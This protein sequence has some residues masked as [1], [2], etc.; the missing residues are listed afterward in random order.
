LERPEIIEILIQSLH[1]PLEDERRVAYEFLREVVSRHGEPLTHR[2]RAAF[3]LSLYHVRRIGLPAIRLLKDCIRAAFRL[4]DKTRPATALARNFLYKIYRSFRL[5]ALLSWIVVANGYF[6]LHDTLVLSATTIIARITAAQT[7]V[8]D[9]AA[10]LFSVVIAVRLRIIT[11]VTTGLTA[12]TTS[13]KSAYSRT[14]GALIAAREATRTALRNAR[15]YIIDH[16]ISSKDRVRDTARLCKRRVTDGI[17]LILTTITGTYI[18]TRTSIIRK[19]SITRTAV[20][21]KY[22][23][24]RA[25]VTRRYT[26]ARTAILHVIARIVDR[27]IISYR[28][29]RRIYADI[30]RHATR[31]VLPQPATPFIAAGLVCLVLFVFGTNSYFVISDVNRKG[32]FMDLGRYEWG[33]EALASILIGEGYDIYLNEKITEKRIK[34]L[35]ASG[36]YYE[37]IIR[38]TGYYSPLPDQEKYATGSY[39]GDIILNGRG[40]MGSDTTPVYIGMAAGP[41][42]MEFGT[43]LIIEDLAKF[44]LPMIY[45]VHDRGGAIQGNRIDIWVGKGEKAMRKAYEITGYY[46]VVVVGD[47]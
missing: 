40:I 37:R 8:I 13:V 14:I 44:G 29:T 45:T 11:T 47:R 1:H 43:N 46:K 5:G 36:H 10:G 22:V 34:E 17:A 15:L 2:S 30:K 32:I 28:L 6:W 27:V 25:A 21:R 31:Q 42:H 41:P 4:P 38:V 16:A 24:T 12:W 26:R 19:Y 3:H 23:M 7:F 20:T 33:D 39:R 9:V 18:R 35:L